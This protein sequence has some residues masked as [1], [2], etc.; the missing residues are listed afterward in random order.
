[1]GFEGL[2][3]MALDSCKTC[4]SQIWAVLVLVHTMPVKQ[5]NR[6]GSIAEAFLQ[7]M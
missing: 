3:F 2:G 6:R 7:R 1:M 4:R 5:A